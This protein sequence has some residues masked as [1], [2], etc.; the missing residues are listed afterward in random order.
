MKRRDFIST[1]GLGFALAPW[2]FPAIARAASAKFFYFGKPPVHPERIFAAGPPAAVLIHCLAPHKLL[3]WPWPIAE[4]DLLPKASAEL[5]MLGKLAGRGSTIPLER[6]YALKPDLIVD[7]GNVDPSYLS[8]AEKTSAQLRLPYY[9]FS[10]R[11]AETPKLLRE[12]GKRFG[13]AERGEL[14]ANYAQKMLD[15]AQANPLSGRVYL[16]RG[17]HGLEAGLAG[18]IHSEVLDYCGL[19]NVA[20]S[21]GSQS[22]GQ[23]SLEQLYDWQ[24][25]QIICWDNAQKQHIL[26][27]R[28]WQNLTAVKTGK[29]QVAPS[30]P[31]G[32]LDG[33][34]SVNR[35]LGLIWLEALFKPDLRPALGAKVADF[36]A[37][38]Y[39]Q[40]PTAEQVNSLLVGL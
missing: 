16:A 22:L 13:E 21:L 35:L 29:L 32:W 2:V 12:A 9:L 19:T 28:A 39:G 20:A 18:S 25:E 15:H 10:T 3:G 11:L 23:V 31:F 6:L 37:L 14:L 8:Q 40:R 24:P 33:P 34:P 17:P 4:R 36:Y 5:P 27:N 1:L 38:F 30:N 7:A 26:N